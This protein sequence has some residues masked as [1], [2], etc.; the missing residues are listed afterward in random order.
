MNWTRVY[1]PHR[2]PPHWSGLVRPGQ[3][4]V[5][6]FDPRTHVPM[7]DAGGHP[8]NDDVSIAI[9]DS[10]E[11]AI[12]FANATVA[13]HPH[14]FCEIYSHEGKSGDPIQSIYNPAER[15]KHVGRPVAWRFTRWGSGVGGMLLARGLLGLREHK[16]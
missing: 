6:L 3:F 10:L 13:T 5:F 15:G 8:S 1:D 11:E 9:C 2:K 16:S 7:D 4:A 12:G 14:V